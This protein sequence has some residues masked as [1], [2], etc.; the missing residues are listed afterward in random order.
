MAV[1]DTEAVG[2]SGG[3][4]AAGLGTTSEPEDQQR[5][6]PG[7]AGG[8]L[9]GEDQDQPI[10]ITKKAVTSPS[11]GVRELLC[12][13]DDTEAVG[14]DDGESKDVGEYE[15][16]RDLA[17]ALL[18]RMLPDEDACYDPY[19]DDDQDF[20]GDCMWYENDPGGMDGI[21]DSD[22]GFDFGFD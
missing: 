14:A 10:Y 20:V 21:D 7:A 5:A 11:H 8:T 22:D 16:R 17:V 19:E 2:A 1:V 6:Q 12:M 4:G 9:P 15:R 18:D 13:A 3:G